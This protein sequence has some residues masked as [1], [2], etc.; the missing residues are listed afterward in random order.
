MPDTITIR[1]I[2]ADDK[3]AWCTLWTAYLDFYETTLDDAV[4]DSSFARMLSGNSGEFQGLVAEQDGVLVGLTHF[5][6]HRSMWSIE[7]TCY[8]MDLY[9]DPSLRGGGVGRKL[10]EA[11]HTIAKE[12]GCS[13]TYWLT[14][15]FNYKGRM[16]YDQVATRTPFI[17]YAKKD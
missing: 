1:P 7:N 6:F 5:L 15:E 11:V 17:K 13:G 8:L 3:P 16:L 14:Q 4:F 9:V 12:N 10:I 2:Q